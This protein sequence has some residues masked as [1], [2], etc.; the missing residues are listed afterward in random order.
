MGLDMYLTGRLFHWSC[1]P[2]R[3]DERRENG[4]K[5][6]SIDVELGYWRKHPNLHGFIV[7]TF[8]NGVDNC[9]EIEL[10]ADNLR[11][12]L[13]AVKAKRL[14]KTEGFFFGSSDGSQEEIANDLEVLNGALDWLAEGDKDP[15]ETEPIGELGGILSGVVVKPRADSE[16]NAPQRVSR[17]VHYMA[18]W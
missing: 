14:P 2:N 17:S 16:V 11:L 15:I 13:K 1:Y 18:S 5:V 10:S 7:Q 8:A 3:D 4:K 12:I 9:E 6:K